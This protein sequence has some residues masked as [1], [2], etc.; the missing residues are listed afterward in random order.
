MGVVEH[1]VKNQQRYQQVGHVHG[2]QHEAFTLRLR[3]QLLRPR[4]VVEQD[5]REDGH[6]S[7][8]YVRGV[9]NGRSPYPPAAPCRAAK[10]KRI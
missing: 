3:S 2:E 9:D 6:Q 7:G 1:G 4:E 10:R 8:S 5:V